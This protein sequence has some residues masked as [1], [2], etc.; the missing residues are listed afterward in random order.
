MSLDETQEFTIE[1]KKEDTKKETINS[2]LTESAA[3][4]L[5]N[6]RNMKIEQE[7]VQYKHCL[8]NR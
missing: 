4:A 5:K 3:N 7:F 2:H 6:E 1:R 8:L